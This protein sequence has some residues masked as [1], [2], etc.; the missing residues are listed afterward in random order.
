MFGNGWCVADVLNYT[1]NNLS[2]YTTKACSVDELAT[3]IC[4]AI[5][6]A[7][8]P[9]PVVFQETEYAEAPGMDWVLRLYNPRF[10]YSL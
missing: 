10:S 6:L 7:D 1:G 4:G 2:I 3:V 9:L 5:D 8:D